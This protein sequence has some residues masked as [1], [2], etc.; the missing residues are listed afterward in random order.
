MSDA[1]TTTGSQI[2]YI[3]SPLLV[4]TWAILNVLAALVFWIWIVG[5]ALYYSNILVHGPPT[6]SELV[7]YDTSDLVLGV[8]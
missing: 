8:R 1:H 2:S 5:S 3:G 4:P 7:W 6:F